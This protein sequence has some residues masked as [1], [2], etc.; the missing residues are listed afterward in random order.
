MKIKRNMPPWGFVTFCDDVRFELED[1]ISLIG[2]YSRR[3]LLPEFP[4]Q[5][6]KFFIYINYFE[7]FNIDTPELQVNIY[8]PGNH[9]SEPNFS[10]PIPNMP[11]LERP[12]VP[13]GETSLMAA[14]V[15]PIAFSPLVF[16][17]AG[18]IKVRMKRGE[19]EI[20]LGVLHVE[21]GV[22]SGI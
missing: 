7:A 17:C 10:Q 8:L 12:N 3:L 11:K 1:K 15:F 9:T 18:E 6:P 20:A 2:V 16:E 21:Q 14:A 5:L 19:E 4:V 22:F 13:V